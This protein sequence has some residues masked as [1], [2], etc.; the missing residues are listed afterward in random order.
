[1]D[2]ELSSN[3]QAPIAPRVASDMSLRATRLLAVTLCTAFVAAGVAVDSLRYLGRGLSYQSAL[4]FLSQQTGILGVEAAALAVVTLGLGLFYGR[5]VASRLGIR[6]PRLQAVHMTVAAA[7][8]A[9]ITL[10]IVAVAAS[11]GFALSVARLV[12][13]F[14]WTDRFPDPLAAG[15]LGFWLI[16]L[17]GLSYFGRRRLGGHRRWRIAHRVVILGVAFSILHTVL[18][19]GWIPGWA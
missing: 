7:T 10:H 3:I 6:L 4:D 17:F 5:G 8:I 18:L 9:T 16:V 15:V 19:S 13:P 2:N 14:M 12:V 11:S 1:M